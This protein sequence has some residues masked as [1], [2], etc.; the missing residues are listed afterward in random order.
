MLI[1][2]NKKQVIDW[3]ATL[4]D[5][6]CESFIEIENHKEYLEKELCAR[7]TYLTQGETITLP[8]PEYL[9]NF[10]DA[11]SSNNFI[12]INIISTEPAESIYLIN[13]DLEVETLAPLDD[14]SKSS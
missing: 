14:N 10:D 2:K 1:N 12:Q 8:L 7:Y 5:Q 9:I 11:S 6:I 3:F 13:T 4:R